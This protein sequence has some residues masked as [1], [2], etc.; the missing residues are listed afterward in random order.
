MQNENNQN[1]Q[2]EIEMPVPSVADVETVAEAVAPMGN[3]LSAAREA[4]RLSVGDAAYALKVGN[5]VIQA[6]EASD[7]QALPG[8]TFT[9]GILRA[10]GRLLD[11][12]VD[13]IIAEVPGGS[14]AVKKNHV[15]AST[16]T[17]KAHPAARRDGETKRQE[18]RMLKLGLVMVVLAVVLAYAMP[19]NLWDETFESA[20]SLVNRWVRQDVV[21]P[22]T[23]S[24]AVPAPADAAKPAESGADVVA[25]APTSPGT[26]ELKFAAP[27]WV[28][29]RD[30][31][32]RIIY[33]Q[34]NAAGTTQFITGAAPLDVLI[35]NARQVQARWRDEPVKLDKLTG[36][37]VSRQVLR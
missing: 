4:K 25:Q 20:Q 36:D 10:Y 19:G 16:A 26:L 11:V 8:R 17:L 6:I 23:D 33:S 2:A 13:A 28:E 31:T 34:L 7:W 18:K 21:Q 29:V 24:A 22:Q 32:G 35:G 14:P 5:K 27:A 3:S 12:P 37:D 9:V 1:P 30:H 15:Q